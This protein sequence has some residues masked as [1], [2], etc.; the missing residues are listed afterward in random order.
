MHHPGKHRQSYWTLRIGQVENVIVS[1]KTEIIKILSFQ[2]RATK[3]VE[4][5]RNTH[6]RS[7]PDCFPALNDFV[8][9]EIPS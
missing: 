6:V 9:D 7:S 2:K 5:D 4:A 3:N 1:S 8:P